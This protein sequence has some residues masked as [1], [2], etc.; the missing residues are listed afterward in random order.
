M[1]KYL[2]CLLLL[3]LPPQMASAQTGNWSSLS[4]NNNVVVY[5]GPG[6]YYYDPLF[7][8]SGQQTV[9]FYLGETSGANTSHVR[10][11]GGNWID[12]GSGTPYIDWNNPPTTPGTYEVEFIWL[13]PGNWQ[14]A[15]A[16]YDLTVVPAA[17]SHFGDND[18]NVLVFWQGGSSY[19][20]RPFLMVEGIDGANINSSN[21]YYALGAPLFAQAISQGADVYILNFN[22]GGRDLFQNADVVKSAVDFLNNSRRG[23]GASLDVAGVSMGGVVV[24]IALGR[25]EVLGQPHNVD[26]FV[27]IDA[28]QQ[29]AVLALT[30]KGHSK[31]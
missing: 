27:S 30:K 14:G 1:Y 17:T 25:M 7:V 20:D 21:A 13:G 31:R 11:D 6:F 8:R 28:P 15:T 29:G 3:A 5:A 10:V 9:R 18:G 26:R 19:N 22:D 16:T 24:R 2:I 23:S 4:L 12:L